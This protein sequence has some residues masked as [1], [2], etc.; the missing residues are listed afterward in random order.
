MIV[1]IAEAFAIRSQP[2]I[3]RPSYSREIVTA[4][5]FPLAVAMLEGGVIGVL[6]K[7]AFHVSELALATILAAPMFAH[8]TSVLWS[9]AARGRP[10][11]A[12]I[13][14]VQVLALLVIASIA[15]LPIG[16]AGPALLVLAV[17]LGRVL[18]TGVV[19]L[20][21]IVWRMNYPRYV[22]AR[23]TGK[24]TL[25]ATVAM[26]IGPLIV[27]VVQDLN[28]RAFRVLYPL[29]AAV[30]FIG[31]LFYRRIRLRGER[32]LLRYERFEDA[33]PTPHGAPDG[34]YEFDPADRASGRPVRDTFWT[35][36][37]RDRFFRQYMTWQFVAG[38]A[39]MM[40]DFAVVALV[41]RL[42]DGQ[43]FEFASSVLLTTTIPL[44][45]TTL[46]LPMWARYLDR[47]HIAEFR[48]RHGLL[49]IAAQAGNWAAASV[50][51]LALLALPRMIQGVSRGAGMLAW[52]LGHNDFA[53]RR[54]VSL[55][56]GIHA[57]L[58]GVRGFIAPYAAI[59]LFSGWNGRELLGLRLPAWDGIGVHVFAVTTALAIVAEFGFIH[60]KM[61]LKRN[62][63]GEPVAD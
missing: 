51:S 9:H 31:V 20:R 30:A 15:V 2:W 55:Y 52:N 25:L 60:L 23:I 59:I 63:R 61:S 40:G 53:D 49:W 54:L 22:R 36:L 35:V 48:A 19:T 8:L 28:D 58:T 43:R 47:V 24:F 6:A 37:R 45:L 14:R 10:K 62:A 7:K 27:Y 12:L 1:R 4:A 57:T 56:M 16:G 50:G 41:I 34:V 46:T 29:A 33:T 26:G 5:T 13:S 42:T 44:L 32:G 3:T 39:N 18:L 17:I 38:L 21:S 11:I